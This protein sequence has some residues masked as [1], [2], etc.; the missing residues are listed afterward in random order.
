M[1]LLLLEGFDHYD[2]SFTSTPQ[3]IFMK[4][5][6]GGLVGRGPGRLPYGAQSA[7]VEVIL[8]N[9]IGKFLPSVPSEVIFG[10]GF[11]VESLA[12]K[13]FCTVG[14]AQVG[15]NGGH[16][17]IYDN[18]NALVATGPNFVT[19]MAWNYIE[20]KFT[21]TSGQVRLNG[22]AEIGP[23]AGAY[24][25]AFTSINFSYQQLGTPTLFIDDLYVAD[26]TGGVN[27]DF[28]G[29][30]VVETLYPISDG[31]YTDW[32]VDI[33]GLHWPRV[34]EYLIDSD[35]SYVHTTTV[36]AKDTYGIGNPVLANTPVY[37]TQLNLGVRKNDAGTRVIEPVIR[38]AGVDHIGPLSAVT[39]GYTFHSWL[40]DTDP[41][42]NPWTYTTVNTDEYGIELVS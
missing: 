41:T 37:G 13:P 7:C 28:L 38:Q 39:A 25:G 9:G 1:A 29:D 10:F 15:L 2:D 16:V 33:G 35:A 3:N 20:G 23:S 4:G 30:L 31:T 6:N 24:S 32:T 12:D 26:T 40:R 21:H 17:A 5:W 19:N 42:G 14:G 11:M 36:G 8:N 27:D 18:T 34:S 22:L